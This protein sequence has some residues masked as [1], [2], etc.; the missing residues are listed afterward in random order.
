[1]SRSLSGQ[2]PHALVVVPTRNSA[3][4]LQACLD[5]LRKQTVLSTVVVVDNHS[6]DATQRIAQGLADLVIV[7]GPERSRQRNLGAQAV[8]APVV[9]FIDSD[10][11]VPP[12]LVE[13]AVAA[14]E[15]GAGAV[16][17]PETTCGTGFW[18]RVRAFE[19][20]FYVGRA[21]EAA[22]FFSRDLFDVCGGFNE[23]LDPGPEDWDLT[24]RAEAVGPV[25]RIRPVIVHNE[26][27]VRYV[28]HCRKKGTYAAGLREFVA[29]HGRAGLRT[30][31][32]RPYLRSPW[33][34][35][36]PHPVL[37]LGVVV[38]KLGEAVAV[39]SALVR[40]ARR[41]RPATRPTDSRGT[42]TLTA[43]RS[44]AQTGSTDGGR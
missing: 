41:G 9:G 23:D 1:M 6:T 33:K 36:W 2:V 15:R 34:L 12:S 35:L 39:V 7:A 28:A 37:G 18:A 32:D 19:R 22:R 30:A 17:V 25:T 29:L 40:D 8:D 42:R 13:E 43:G 21:V 31:F 11:I 10:M 26:G 24:L 4:S 14:I 20:S 5:S 38:L 44:G 16:I 27:R 3:K